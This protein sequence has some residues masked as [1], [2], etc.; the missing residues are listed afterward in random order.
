MFQH[1][2]EAT[3]SKMRNGV[4]LQAAWALFQLCAGS[5][6]C[7]RSMCALQEHVRSMAVTERGTSAA[8]VA[9]A[10]GSSDIT[11]DDLMHW[12]RSAVNPVLSMVMK[13]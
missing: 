5:V 3:K 6:E 2:R 1:S 11:V 8:A 7:R 13:P 10:A 12:A 9:L 4:V